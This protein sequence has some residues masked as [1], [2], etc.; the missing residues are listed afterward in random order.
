MFWIDYVSSSRT[1]HEL[2]AVAM[3]TT[4]TLS[5]SAQGS[6]QHAYFLSQSLWLF[7]RGE[8]PATVHHA[9]A[10]KVREFGIGSFVRRTG[11]K[12]HRRLTPRAGGTKP[13]FSDTQ[14]KFGGVPIGADG[15]PTNALSSPAK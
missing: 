5:A 15:D 10:L 14:W 8:V 4:G 7:H 9:P 6:E 1:F 3:A 11:V 2:L 12:R 13:W